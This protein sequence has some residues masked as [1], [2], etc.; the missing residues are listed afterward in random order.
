VNLGGTITRAT[1]GTVTRDAGNPGTLNL[2]GTLNLGA[3]TLEAAVGP[4]TLAN[5][6]INGGTVVGTLLAP[7]GINSLND[8]SLSGTLHLLSSAFS[9]GT[10]KVTDTAHTGAGLTF[11]GGNVRMDS[12]TLLTFAD[13]QTL[14]GGGAV[15]ALGGTVIGLSGANQTLTIAPGITITS[16]G[17]LDVGANILINQGTLSG[18]GSISGGIFTV[19]G[20]N[21]I[22]DG[23][24]NA[25]KGGAVALTGTWTNRGTIEVDS[26]TL[27]ASGTGSNAGSIRATA[28]TL[29]LAVDAFTNTGLLGATSNGNLILVKSVAIDQFGILYGQPETTITV[30]ANLA[31]STLN[32]D[33][34]AT[35]GTVILAGSGSAASPQLFEVMSN[36]A[37]KIAAGFQKNFAY[38]AIALANNTYVKLVDNAHNSAGTGPEA[39]YAGS[40]LVPAG[41]TLDL[42]GLHFYA[43]AAQISGSVVNGSV[44]LVP[45]GGPV[46]FTA[47]TPGNLATSGQVDDWTF[48]GRAGRAVQVFVGTGGGSLFAPLSPFLN[49]AQVQLLGPTGEIVATTTN[50]SSGADAVLQAVRLP[51]DGTYHIRV[52]A[53]PNHATNTGNYLLTLWDAPLHTAA[54]NLNENTFGQLVSPYAVDMWTFTAAANQQVRFNLIST[55]MAGFQFD[56]TGPNGY[57]AF[58]GATTSSNL[59]DLPTAGTYTLTVHATHPTMGAY[60]FDILSTSLSPLA[61]GVPYSGVFAGS[62]QAQLFTIAT[63]QDRELLIALKGN[64][65]GDHVEVY[66]RFNAPPTRADYQYKSAVPNSLSQTI[67][68]PKA[69]PGTWYI[70]IYA[71]GVAA[72]PDNFTLT[73]TVVPLTL[74]ALVPDHSGNAAAAI[75]T[76]AGAGFDRT[77][78]VSLVAGNGTAYQANQ[79]LLDL[80]TQLSA[81]FTAGSV[82]AG[83][84]SVVVTQLDGTTATLPNAFTMVQGGKSI[85]KS[86]LVVPSSLGN[87]MASTLYLQYSNSG[88]LP[89][90][91]PIIEVTVFQDFHGTRVQKALL[92]LDSALAGKGFDTSVVIAGFS[93]TVQILGSGASPGVLLPGES[94]TVPIYWGGWVLPRDFSNPD[95]EP[96]VGVEDATDST[97]IPWSELQASFRPPNISTTAWNAM[98]PFLKAQVGNTWGGFVQ[99][100]DNDASYLGH[101]GQR[102][103]DIN[104]LWAFEIQQ[105]NGFSPLQTL[106]EDVDASAPNLGPALS[107]TRAFPNSIQARNQMGPFGWGWEWTDGWQRILSVVNGVPTITNPDGGQRLFPPDGRGGF[108][109]EPGDHGTLMALGGGVFTLQEA[110]GSITEFQADGKVAFVADTNGNKVNAVYTNGL[111]TSL[112]ASAGQSLSFTWNSAGRITSISDTTGRTTTYTYDPTNQ[113]LLAVSPFDDDDDQYAYDTSGNPAAQNALV[114]I[115]HFNNNATDHFVYNTRGQLVET[116][117][118][119]DADQVNYTYGSGGEVSAADANGATANAFFDARGL[120]AKVTDPLG[121]TTHYSYDSNFNLTQVIDPA[122]QITLHSYDHNGNRIKTTG[123]DGQTVAYAYSGP[124]NNMTSYT[125]SNGHA[126]NYHYDSKGNLLAISYAD[127]SQNQFNY[128]PLGNISQSISARGQAIQNVHNSIG[129]L[130]QQSFA[131]GSSLAYAYDA[132]GNLISAS[133]GTNTTTFQFDLTGDNLLQVNYPGGRFLKFSYDEGDRRTQSVD[134]NGITVNYTYNLGGLLAG[135]T[136]GNGNLIVLYTYDKMDRLIRTD[137]GNLTYATYDYDLAGNVLHLV[138][139]APDGSI[140]SRFDYTYDSLGR[141]TSMT[142]LDG[143]WTYQLDPA[144]QLIR[145]VFASNDPG[146]VPNQDLQ[147]VYDLAGNRTQT[148]SNGVATTYV[149]D[150]MNRYTQIGSATLSYDADGNLIAQTDNTG[151]TS[152]T[153]DALNR[154]IGTSSPTETSTYQYDPL[155]KLASMTQDS[156]TT[157]YVIDPMGL[158]DVVGEY[159]GS[160]SLI[161]NFTFGLGLTSRVAAGGETTYYDFDALGSTVGMSGTAGSYENTYRYL[162]FGASLSSSGTTPNPFQFVGQFGIMAQANGT[163]FMRARFYS[164][165]MGRFLTRD[166]IGLA[167]GQT[168]LFLY[169]ANSPLSFSD[170]TGLNGECISQRE[171]DE[172]RRLDQLHEERS[173]YDIW[174]PFPRPPVCPPAPPRG[175][176]P[177]FTPDP[178]TNGGINMFHAPNCEPPP[179]PPPPPPPGP[180]PPAPPAPPAPPKPHSSDPNEKTGPGGFG[181]EAFIRGDTVLPY[182]IEFENEAKATAPAQ[183]VIVTDP[184]N[185]SIDWSTLQFIEVGFGGNIIAIPA[186]SQHFQTKVTMTYGGLTFDVLIEL[187]FNTRTGLITATFQSIDPNTNLP[188][189]VLIGF[190]PPE[191]GTGRGFGHFSYTAMLKTG[192]PTGS[193]ISNV[194]TIIFDDNQPIT[195]DQVDP[196]DASKGVDPAKQAL[197]TIDAV[198]PTGNVAALPALSPGSF[199]VSWAGQDDAGGSGISDF[200]IYVSDNGGAYT[201]WQ[202]DTSATSAT[203]VGVDGHTYGF[204]STAFDNAGNAQPAAAGAQT[205]TTV[206]AAAPTSTVA[207]LSAFS[208]PSFTLTWS[209]SDNT[210][211]SGL[212]S[213][214]IYVSDNGAAFT[215]F[216]TNTTATTATFTGAPE[217]SYGFYSIATDLD[218]NV[219]STPLAAQASTQTLLD[220][221]NKQYVAAV[222]IDLLQ[223]PVDLGGLNYWSGRLDNHENRTIIAALL[224]HSAEYFQTNVIKPAYQ[225]FLNRAADQ[226]GLNYWTGQLQGG[227][228]DEQMQ[229]GFI[230]S[231]EFYGIAN[232]GGNSVPVTPA[233]DRAWVDALF[234][235]LLERSP[236]QDGENYWTG[237]LQG[238]QSRIEVANGF[239]GSTE[240]LSL[241]VQQTYQRY[242]GRGADADGLAYWLSQYRLGA[243][244]EDIVTGFIGSDEFFNQATR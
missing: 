112:A 2:T 231:P 13:T 104:Q 150:G 221:P 81:T 186:S 227:V 242:L 204:Y 49:F 95:F 4:L 224:T 36:D 237:Q 44:S 157:H 137:D 96:E 105:V 75:L 119:G 240:G 67:I 14:A 22:N 146:V 29:T 203:F 69:A 99:R 229:A 68:V 189:D 222:Y 244:N 115:H 216:L 59:I 161:A 202:S 82:P 19:N 226:G 25:I 177:C 191:D 84:Y 196:H 197:N 230:A 88:D 138:N 178:V 210:G 162:P 72:L 127:G 70:L 79:T 180:T 65:Q 113:Y 43:R 181:P 125:D 46:L 27:N 110:T 145:A 128:D 187:G 109:P 141:R 74:T 134:Q 167:G 91:A 12:F 98:F 21:W 8:V 132:R 41:T 135:L 163:D 133:D 87:H 89:M 97:P 118:N 170:P 60:A 34:Y 239:T 123:P 208:K 78:R 171:A 6:T 130:T 86:N 76:L 45:G 152:Y 220:S 223:R 168:N 116:D 200:N 61:S 217:H 93:N 159:N 124:F 183:L 175:P 209:G 151:A 126:T 56:L 176:F 39:V 199:I 92:T 55:A 147:Y 234:E 188:P 48:F 31:G 10:V 232:G 64:N 122:G 235:T 114:S 30:Q 7:S 102:V 144:G 62:G 215:A 9:V 190:L 47:L 38:G 143:T 52:Q 149:V 5:G 156:Q 238:I 37:G 40:L 205:T 28:G 214:T 117:R 213:Y 1:L 182:R 207:A 108:F 136:D 193:R 169:V 211:G 32:A 185:A 195:T 164:P 90:P 174:Y 194:A 225:Q 83:N 111:L 212:A 192:L 71:E 198:A 15:T 206:D 18:D 140:N 172:L 129:E 77:S 73:A 26:G 24:I 233:H 121:N 58:S 106:H 148:I 54:L 107:V 20:T 51:A 3:Q 94:I 165:S 35:Q 173:Q 42:N 16:G 33:Q 120:L 243:V 85:F 142:M 57:T 131:D 166:P 184:L 179:P 63:P 101:L 80:P 17:S 66:A 219:Q 139:H 158:G 241:R 153:F 100:L 154:L 103:I 53:D 228:T 50:S 155:G 160:G 236:D 23:T 218:G 201:L 11:R